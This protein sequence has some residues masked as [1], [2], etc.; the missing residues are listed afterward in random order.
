TSYNDLWDPKH[1][2]KVG[3]IDIQYVGVLEA[4]ALVSGGNME[5][6]EP[7]KA[8]L[9]ELRKMD[10]KM[11]PTNEAMAQ[12]LK[13]GEVGRA[14]MREGRGGEGGGRDV[15]ERGRAGA[16]G[17]AEGRRR[18]LRLR[19]RD[20]EERAEQDRGL[21]LSRRD[22]GAFGADRLRRDDGLQPDRVERE[23]ARRG[24]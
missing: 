6:F 17:G 11:Y 18:P 12:A 22:A 23:G 24:R 15:A 3:V 20:S 21:R 2:G 8:K 7:G 13:T 5:N 19:L 4:A 9:M 10:F 14:I 16:G 1:K